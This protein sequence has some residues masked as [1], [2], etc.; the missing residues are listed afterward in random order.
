MTYI[1]LQHQKKTNKQTS[2]QTNKQTNNKKQ[3]PFKDVNRIL[4]ILKHKLNTTYSISP[5]SY[6]IVVD[7]IECP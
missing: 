1:E 2:K 5:K 6:V 3:K 4:N 7:K